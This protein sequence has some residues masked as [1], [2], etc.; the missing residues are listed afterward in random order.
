MYGNYFHAKMTIPLFDWME[1]DSVQS[2]TFYL[3]TDEFFYVR[4]EIL[5]LYFG[6]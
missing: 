5:P 2:E 3:C 1:K 4:C 6:N